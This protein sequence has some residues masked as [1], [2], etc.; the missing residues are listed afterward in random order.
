VDKYTETLKNPNKATT[1][2]T[3]TRGGQFISGSLTPVR[4]GASAP[5]S[6]VI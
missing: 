1:A 3:H 5:A 4:P 6:P 2:S